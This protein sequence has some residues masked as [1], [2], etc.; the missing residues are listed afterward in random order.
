[1]ST[2]YREI[3][4]ELQH[5]IEEGE[6]PPGSTLPKLDELMERYG[7]A[8]QTAR[9]AIAELTNLGLVTPIRR[10]G[11]VVRDCKPL[12]YWATRSEASERR[13]SNHSDA[14]FTDVKESN[15]SP[16]QEFLST[17]VK[18]PA[19]IAKLLKI[20][21]GA[22]V[23]L[24]RC[25]RSVDNEPWSIQDSYFPEDIVALCPELKSPQ[26]ITRGTIRALQEVGVYQVGFFDE[27]VSRM[28]TS[29]EHEFLK[30]PRGVPVLIQTR[31]A[32]TETRIV[33]VTVTTWAGDR[34]RVIY[35]VGDLRALY[36]Q[37]GE[38]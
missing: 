7:V 33:R 2:S 26:D 13:S 10:R 36:P 20:Q 1:M 8:R 35:E 3:A 12:T 4:A 37:D 24:R 38:R 19:N 27:L 22:P 16:S 15:R 23:V 31:S 18:A 25:L 34:N 9:S 6:L 14:Y 17:T 5:A 28:P 11:T 30:T 32:F 21:P 29:E